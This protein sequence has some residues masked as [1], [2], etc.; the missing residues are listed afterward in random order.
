MLLVLSSECGELGPPTN[1]RLRLT[2][3]TTVTYTCNQGYTLQGANR[4]TCMANGE[5]SGSTPTCNRK[6]L[7]VLL[8]LLH[9]HQK[10]FRAKILHCDDSWG[11]TWIL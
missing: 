8:L 1:G 4:R 11:F 3:F 9:G 5:W 6:L 2:N 10:P 7:A